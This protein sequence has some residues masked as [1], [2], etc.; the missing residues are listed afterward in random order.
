[1]TRGQHK[2]FPKER[3]KHLI[4]LII[5]GLFIALLA[6]L[7]RIA[8]WYS[9]AFGTMAF[10]VVVYQLSTPLKGTSQW[11]IDS[12]VYEVEMGLLIAFAIFLP[13]ALFDLMTFSND[14]C[15]CLKLFRREK[16][17]LNCATISLTVSTP[18]SLPA[19]ADRQLIFWSGFNS[20][21]GTRIPQS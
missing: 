21:I 9:E 8:S 17:L 10:S 5:T 1:M 6:I 15:I 4:G 12:V 14:V 13:I 2:A 18:T 7:I 3:K 16:N 19:L 20:R 11:M